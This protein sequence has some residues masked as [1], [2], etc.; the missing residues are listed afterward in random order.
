MLTKDA[1]LKKD[2]EKLM[3][4][5]GADIIFLFGSVL[6]DSFREDSDID[7]GIYFE[8]IRYDKNSVCNTIIDFFK[9]ERIDVA[10]LNEASPLLLYQVVKKGKLM[11]YKSYLKMVE[12]QLRCLKKY[13]ETSKFRKMKERVLKDYIE[14]MG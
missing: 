5:I 14:R 10:F 6:S 11:A 9:T 3:Q 2:Y 1:I 13:W 8:S 12:F 7:I 4:L